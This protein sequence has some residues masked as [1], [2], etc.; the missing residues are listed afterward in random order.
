[1]SETLVKVPRKHGKR[2]K[3]LQEL[4]KK[5]NSSIIGLY[6]PSNESS[7]AHYKTLR[8]PPEECVPLSSRDKAPFLMYLEIAYT[9]K[10][11]YDEDTFM[12]YHDFVH[13]N[14]HGTPWSPGKMAK[15]A[16]TSPVSVS[17]SSSS[18]SS[19]Q[20]DPSSDSVEQC[21]SPVKDPMFYKRR[22]SVKNSTVLFPSSEVTQGQDSQVTREKTSA[23]E[24]SKD[25][26]RSATEK[27]E[28]KHRSKRGSVKAAYPKEHVKMAFGEDWNQKKRRLRALSRHGVSEANWDLKSVIFKG[29]DDCRQEVLAMQLIQLFNKT[30]KEAKLPLK[31][32]PY[33]V[34]V[35]SAKS[36]LIETIPNS[37]SI[38]SLK[39]SHTG[40]VSLAKFFEDF[41]GPKGSP[42]HTNAQR[43]FVE[44]MAAYS[45]VSYFLQVKDRHNGNIMLD[46]EGHIIHIDFGFMLSNSP[47][48]N[49]NFESCPFK[50]TQEFIEVME[51]EGSQSYNYFTI[52]ICRAYYHARACADKILLL[53]ESMMVGSVGKNMDC[54]LGGPNTLVAL[55][56]RFMLDGSE[57]EC[58]EHAVGLLRESICNWR[59]V[60]YDKYQTIVNDIL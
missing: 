19:S 4:V 36:G 29:G 24:P 30:W 16:P 49:I 54:F 44:S 56:D 42:G 14:L 6:F 60:Q 1:M 21:S 22:N 40:F 58:V 35:T 25:Q 27:K 38:D 37:V 11:V 20:P 41:F 51:G 23:V 57:S 5:M 3:M 31:L 59:T 52:L 32:R 46:S 55:R 2:K 53:V 39:K 7:D 34:M 45:I 50:L 47:G 43:N 13:S 18:D 26:D 8:I 48:G 10:S 17:S 15:K 28:R 33:S 9:N 12:C